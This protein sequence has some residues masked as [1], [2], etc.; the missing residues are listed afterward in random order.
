MCRKL[1]FLKCRSPYAICLNQKVELFWLLKFN[2]IQKDILI[3][4][5]MRHNLS[6]IFFEMGKIFCSLLCVGFD[7]PYSLHL[8][9]LTVYIWPALQFTFDRPYCLHL[10]WSLLLMVLCLPVVLKYEILV[11]V[12][13]SVVYCSFLWQFTISVFCSH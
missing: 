5:K 6:N 9:D 2:H 1:K 11:H 4:R 7:R 8:T 3:E 10:S 12:Q 13:C